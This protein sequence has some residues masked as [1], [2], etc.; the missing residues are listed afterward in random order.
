MPLL[1]DQ[2]ADLGGTSETLLAEQWHTAA[3]VAIIPA[4]DAEGIFG[5]ARMGRVGYMRGLFYGAARCYAPYSCL[6]DLC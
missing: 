6:C 1:C 2:W 5:L 3:P 4:H